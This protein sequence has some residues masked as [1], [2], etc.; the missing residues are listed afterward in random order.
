MEL[1]PSR[2]VERARVYRALASLFHFPSEGLVVDLREHQ[3]PELRNALGRLQADENLLEPVA[4][5]AK[6]VVDVDPRELERSYERTF[7]APGGLR[8]LPHE[9]AH[10]A[11]KPVE[12]M[13]STFQLADIAGFYRAFGVE[14]A[15]GT[16][17]VDHIVAELEF[18][19]LLAVKEAVA[20]TDGSP[21]R[22]EVC[23]DAARAFLRDHLSR[24]TGRFAARLEDSDTD[25]LYAT[26]GC[27]LDRFV[28][29]DAAQLS[30]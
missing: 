21:E 28:A 25:C 22:A 16:E 1:G 17:H 15:P 19:H 9:T 24:W 23:R 14:V 27:L 3:V 29:L 30:A 11:E 13:L 12:A 8:C 4:Q 26:A 5:L 6:R 10:A 2:N 20:E 7:E 18:M